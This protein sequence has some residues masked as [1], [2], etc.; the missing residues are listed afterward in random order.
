MSNG[1]RK[2]TS[3]LADAMR[4]FFRNRPAVVA[5][6]MI[7]LLA[8][9]AVTGSFM[10]G[11]TPEASDL[12][13][14]EEAELV[15][16]KVKLGVNPDAKLDP[17]TTNLKDTFLPPGS[18]S[19]DK[20]EKRYYLGTDHLGRDVLARLWAGSTIS[21]SIG[22]LAV[23]ISVL[24]GIS[25]GGIAG[26]FGRSRVGLPVLATLLLALAGGI[27][28]AAEFHTLAYLAFGATGLLF[29]LQAGIAVTGGRWRSVAAWGVL[30]LLFLLMLAYNG[31]VEGSTPEGRPIAHAAAVHE[32]AYDL[33]LTLRD[34]GD[35]VKQLELEGGAELTKDGK[36]TEQPG[37]RWQGQTN[38]EVKTR[39]V[40]WQ[41]TRYQL[42]MQYRDFEVRQRLGIEQQE[43]A[44]HLAGFEA[45]YRERFNEATA[46][47][48][49]LRKQQAAASDR[50]TARK[51]ADDAAAAEA[52]ASTFNPDTLKQRAEEMK[53][54]G[55]ENERAG[56]MIVDALAE[57]V[58]KYRAALDAAQEA[59]LDLLERDSSSAD[60]S[61]DTLHALQ[62]LDAD[63]K[64]AQAAWNLAVKEAQIAAAPA[65]EGNGPEAVEKTVQPSAEA[66]K[67]ALE[68]AEAARKD[69]DEKKP[70]ELK[71]GAVKP[72]VLQS[73][74]ELVDRRG[75]VRKGQVDRYD[76]ETKTRRSAL[77]NAELLNG[78][79][80]YSIYKLTRHF[81]AY[82][83]LIV[84]VLSAGLVVLA[85]GQTAAQEQSGFNKLYLPTISV[86]DLV[87]RFTE[88]MMTIPVIFLILAVLAMFE[89]DVYI[90]MGVIG[91]T[92]WMGT[93]RFVRA[94]IL[95]LRE[96]DFIQA[97]RSLGVSDFRI[98]WRHLVPNAIS[99]VLVSASI[100]VAGAVLAESTLSFLGIGAGP[101]QN[102][103][104]KILSEGREFINDAAWLTWIP[105]IA[106]LI[107][108]LAFN[109]LGEG[110]REA[111]NPKLRGR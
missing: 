90:T 49:E 87:M 18:I 2:P 5:A 109:L 54:E 12:I 67:K 63:A 77:Y 104:G 74:N 30:T 68:A 101:D 22:F 69:L 36:A 35:E 70:E 73:S 14:L 61:W 102:T 42:E 24:L 15:G 72:L 29:L 50:D 88:I 37:W 23:G 45:D 95:S 105:G 4:I 106:I 79:S 43:R 96:Q 108:V 48:T 89:K 93:T 32:N 64:V 39:A 40:N 10:T 99:P 91:L 103:W 52:R 9:S 80:R 6:A 57:P 47:A 53:I 65:P 38:V 31:S 34:F 41:L 71:A 97:A 92:S 84:L 75:K 78:E 26:Y 81:L 56:K 107:T 60:R 51:L 16:D 27:L 94:E 13:R 33:L 25:L 98:I 1:T 59:M 111:F 82:L 76:G 3:P 21:L 20:P 8:L 7:L 86:D 28:F 66:E 62:K 58:E 17:V 85:A 100:G 19:E 55:A 46:T 44:A 11:K 83:V 110:L